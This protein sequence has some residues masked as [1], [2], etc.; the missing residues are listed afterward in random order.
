M[1]AAPVIDSTMF[2]TE[3]GTRAA[4]VFQGGN[5]RLVVSIGA[6]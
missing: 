5:P 6:T 3:A 1:P 4:V 2:Y